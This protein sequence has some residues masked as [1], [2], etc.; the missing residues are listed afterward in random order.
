M[1]LGPNV[2]ALVPALQLF[3]SQKQDLPQFTPPAN[4]LKETTAL[5]LGCKQTGKH[6]A[7]V[8]FLSLSSGVF[9]VHLQWAVTRQ[10]DLLVTIWKTFLGSGKTRLSEGCATPSL[11]VISC[12]Q[13]VGMATLP[14]AARLRLKIGAV[15]VWWQRHAEAAW[16][17]LQSPQGMAVQ[18]AAARGSD[19][20][21]P[22]APSASQVSRVKSAEAET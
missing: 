14:H 11:M 16:S 21:S 8:W 13:Q 10:G 1:R 20:A 9:I 4:G 6:L 5:A 18:G 19:S 15:E 12:S 3:K 22:P 2:Q 17:D 7:R